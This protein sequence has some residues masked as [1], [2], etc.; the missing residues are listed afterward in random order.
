MHKQFSP[1]ITSTK[2][3][4]QS[5]VICAKKK[6]SGGG[7]KQQKKSGL[8]IPTKPPYVQTQVITHNLLLIQ[9]YFKH[10]GR[11]ILDQEVDISEAIK[12]LWEAPFALLAHDCG[13]S[14]SPDSTSTTDSTTSSPESESES[15]PMFVYGNAKALALF[16][17]TWD[18]LLTTPSSKSADPEEDV[19]SDRAAALSAALANGHV[20]NYSGWRRSFQGKR[21]LIKNAT[22]FNVDSPSGERLGQAAILRNWEYE[23][24]SEDGV[25]G[26]KDSPLVAAAKKEVALEKLGEE[27]VVAERA[28]EEQAAVVRELKEGEGLGNGD[29]RVKKA[30]GELLKR[31][32]RLAVLHLSSSG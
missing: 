29:E 10:T 6:G 3:S 31:K 26:Y 15:E 16:E 24:G 18:E 13:L 7:S 25:D 8:I 22:I 17:C 32:D 2:P 23:D 14:S 21:F 1:Q 28:V 12:A 20:D 19:Q 4:R 27:R 5:L 11:P 9:S 30:V